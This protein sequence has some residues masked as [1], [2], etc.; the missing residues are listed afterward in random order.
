MHRLL[1][2]SEEFCC[3]SNMKL[4]CVEDLIVKEKEDEQFDEDSGI[5]SRCV[6]G[7]REIEMQKDGESI[8]MILTEVAIV[9]RWTEADDGVIGGENADT[10]IARIRSRKCQ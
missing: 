7:L 5:R 1:S 6:D 10:T 2:E 9:L 8:C 4:V 3:W